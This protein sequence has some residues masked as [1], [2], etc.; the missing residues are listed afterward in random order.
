MMQRGGVQTPHAQLSQI[1]AAFLP[2][3]KVASAQIKWRS[4]GHPDYSEAA[5][6]IFCP[7]LPTLNARLVLIGHRSRVPHK[8]SY[9]LLL[10]DHRVLALDVNPAGF[11]FNADTFESVNITHWQVW[12]MTEAAPDERELS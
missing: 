12:P 5:V 6:P 7:S 3:A 2:A 4:K 9:S 1:V 11:Q 8:Y 10:G